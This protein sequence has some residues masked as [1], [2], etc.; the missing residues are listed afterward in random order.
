MPSRSVT[1]RP[2]EPAHDQAGGQRLPTVPAGNRAVGAGPGRGRAARDGVGPVAMLNDLL[3]LEHD[4]L[5]AYRIAIA[6]LRDPARRERLQ[7]FRDDHLRHVDE[8]TRLIEARGGVPLRLPHLPTGLFKL[9]V[10]VAGLPGG[11]RAILLAFRANERQSREKYRR[12]AAEHAGG[13]GREP[14]L[15]GF[16]R[17]AAEDEA[18]HYAW[19]CGSLEEMGLGRRTLV[20][21]ANGAFARFHGTLA[22]RIEGA[23]RLWLEIAARFGRPG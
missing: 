23:G 21:A 10:Q 15:A 13:A 17:R 19:V 1:T 9:A 4:A 6:G 7:A 22:D 11:D 16:L 18:R 5:P 2:G 8:L 14:E 20:G 12:R 3:Q